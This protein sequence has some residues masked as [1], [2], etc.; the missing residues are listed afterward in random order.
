MAVQPVRASAGYGPAGSARSRRA[1]VI[2]ASC[3]ALAGAG[4]AARAFQSWRVHP[5]AVFNPRTYG[6]MPSD[7]FDSE[8]G[9][10]ILA[11]MMAVILAGLRGPA[12]AC[13]SWYLR[14]AGLAGRWRTA[15]ACAATAAAAVS[16][17]FLGAFLDP[18]APFGQIEHGWRQIYG[19]PAWG[20]LA[21]S[22]SF[23]IAGTAMI[24]VMIAARPPGAGTTRQETLRQAD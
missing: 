21:L 7:F 12:T 20:L 8:L 2:L 14:S 5:A 22:G 6:P 15:W 19:H 10:L 4:F 3:W 24:T 9:A 17:A 23:L 13:G 16:V 18:L 1:G 11:V